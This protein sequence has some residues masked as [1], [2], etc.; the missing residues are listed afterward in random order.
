MQPDSLSS[1]SSLVLSMLLIACTDSS[2][3]S[4][5]E[6]VTDLDAN[7][8]TQVNVPDPGDA[9]AITDA[10]ISADVA[11][12]SALAPDSASPDESVPDS[13]S[14]D[15]GAPS[16]TTSPS[17]V[18]TTPSL[19]PRT[20]IWAYSPGTL[21]NNTCGEY[22]TAE[23]ATPF[24][25]LTSAD[26]RFEIEQE[27]GALNFVCEVSGTSFLC[28]T[29]LRGESPIE[30]TDVIIAYNVAVEGEVLSSESL[31]GDQTV[32]VTCTGSQC[33]FAPAVLGVT[34]PCSWQVPCTAEFRI[35]E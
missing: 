35:R 5:G 8:D 4:G 24:R 7:A 11:D 23:A 19:L 17:D 29:R 6:D 16:D 3:T 12:S 13:A 10:E 20:G 28:P 1:V 33:A 32:T 21:Q 25:V 34:F 22:A 15:S 30:N 9:Q 2:A 14:P 18:T 27:N 31:R 26:A